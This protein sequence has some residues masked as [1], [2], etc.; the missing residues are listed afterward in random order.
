MTALLAIE[1]S[2]ALCSVAIYVNGRWVEHTQNVERLHNQ[3]LLARIDSLVRAAGMKPRGFDAVAFGAGPGSF[4]GVRIAA[5]AAQAVAL[6]SAAAIV[7]VSSSHALALAAAG[8]D[9]ARGA[10]GVVTLTRSRRDAYYLAAYTWQGDSCRQVRADGLH[11]GLVAPDLG[12]LRDWV[13]VG[14]EPPWWPAAAP[15]ARFLAGHCASALEVGRLGLQAY[16]RGAGLAPEAGLPVYVSGDSPWRPQAGP[17][18]TG[19]P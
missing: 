18:T 5:A 3:V 19:A 9:E 16:Q 10:P 2:G 12:G 7:P 15:G 6:A 8:D 13:G 11:Q 17:G 4:T 14:D 1:T